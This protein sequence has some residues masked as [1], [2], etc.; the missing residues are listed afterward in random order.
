LITPRHVLQLIAALGVALCL[1]GVGGM[2]YHG[3]I[4]SWAYDNS[5]AAAW[6]ASRAD[7]TLDRMFADKLLFLGVLG[8]AAFVVRIIVGFQWRAAQVPAAA[9]QPATAP[10]LHADATRGPGPT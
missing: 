10:P 7:F 6:G 2:I 4:N 8:L 9:Q 3:C 5:V 1:A